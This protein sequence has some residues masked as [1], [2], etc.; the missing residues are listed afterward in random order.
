MKKINKSIV[1]LLVLMLVV[2]MVPF[3]DVYTKSFS[4]AGG[5]ENSRSSEFLLI[6]RQLVGCNDGLNR[7]IFTDEAGNEVDFSGDAADGRQ[8][9]DRLRKRDAALPASYNAV[10]DNVVT[11]IKNQGITGCCWAFGALKSLESSSIRKG[12]LEPD[13][14]DFSENHLAWYS[15]NRMEEAGHPLYGDGRY[16]FNDEEIYDQGGNFYTAAA[17]LANWW[18]A[19]E[20]QDAPFMADTFD[21]VTEMTAFMLSADESLRTESVVHL[22]NTVNYDGADISEKKR[23]VMKNGSMSVSLYFDDMNIYESDGRYSMY[24]NIYDD[25]HANHVVTIV[26]WDDNFSSFESMPPEGKG[27]WLIANSY[28]SEWGDDGYFWV[29]YY[30][31]SLCEF[32]TF[33]ADSKD[34]YDTNFGYDGA[35]YESILVS[36]EDASF[37]NVF[38]NT[39]SVPQKISAAAFYTVTDGQE[40]EVSIYRK[41][42]TKNPA[43]GLKA[44]SCTTRGTIDYNGFHTVPLNDSIIIAPGE[45]FSVIVKFFCSDNS[46]YIPIEGTNSDDKECSFGSMPDQSFLYNSDDDTWMD[47]TCYPDEGEESVNYNNVCV[48]ALG[49]DAS[50]EEYKKQEDAI[51]AAVPT[52][53]GVPAADVNNNHQLSD[54]L[55]SGNNDKSLTVPGIHQL[56]DGNDRNISVLNIAAKYRKI[57]IGK[58]E[59]A[60]LSYNFVPT[61]ATDTISFK[62]SNPKVVSVNSR[63]IVQGKK[64]GT[65]VITLT[66]SSGQTASVTVTV[67][68]AP[69]SVKVKA[70]KRVLKKGRSTKLKVRL[71]K[72]SASFMLSFRSSDKKIAAVD[73]KGLVKANRKGKVRI[74]VRTFN[75]KE[76]TVSL[77]VK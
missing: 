61:D 25:K 49:I 43:D 68:K 74:T 30:D 21:N 33:E 42:N 64:T 13:G 72:K 15:Y 41:L 4:G 55:N 58:G 52:P 51:A 3:Q 37:A 5:A 60:A 63:G 47:A 77:T 73:S 23:A 71:P 28:G 39:G 40:Y 50:E 32:V 65:S 14:A 11:G 10:E 36:D 18:G 6:N 75:G 27:A 26:G 20:E 17:T 57:N 24:Q 53:T 48:K 38:T 54:T 16:V 46:V 9:S 69:S 2:W 19:V 35:G 31:D 7:Y 1:F 76:G 66:S 34:N 12:L 70:A 8:R 45:S 59:K 44:D 62:S 22:L 29:S 56:S 67:K